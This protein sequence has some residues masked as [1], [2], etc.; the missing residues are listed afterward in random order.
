MAQWLGGRPAST[1]EQ[2]H[3]SKTRQTRR[4][5]ARHRLLHNRPGLKWRQMLVPVRARGAHPA[6]ERRP[7]RQLLA[8]S[9]QSRS[10]AS[11]PVITKKRVNKLASEST[12]ATMCY[13]RRAQHVSQLLRDRR[14]APRSRQQCE[15]HGVTVVRRHLQLPR[16][17]V[18]VSGV[19]LLSSSTRRPHQAAASRSEAAAEGAEARS[20]VTLKSS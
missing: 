2:T 11:G 6:T 5:P 19:W 14:H 13:S 17:F 20:S 3:R 10:A 7:L 16:N 12:Q 8:T 15:E 9:S 1:G 4:S 18:R